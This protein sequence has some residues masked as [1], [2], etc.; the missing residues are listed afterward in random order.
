MY[1]INSY[2]S[3]NSKFIFEKS[4]FCC[5]AEIFKLHRLPALFKLQT[6]RRNSSLMYC[7]TIW[8]CENRNVMSGDLS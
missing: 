6:K 3:S 4:N 2:F 1:V 5:V 8:Q 7:I